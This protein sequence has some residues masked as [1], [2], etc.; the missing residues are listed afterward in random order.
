MALFG[1]GVH[2]WIDFLWVL[3]KALLQALEGA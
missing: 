1:I 2:L 3:E